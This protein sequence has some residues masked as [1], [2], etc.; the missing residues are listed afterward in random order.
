MAPAHRPPPKIKFGN[1]ADNF[2]P[3]SHNRIVWSSESVFGP[4]WLLVRAREVFNRAAGTEI[5]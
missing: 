5:N 2:V 3:L 4:G 1:F